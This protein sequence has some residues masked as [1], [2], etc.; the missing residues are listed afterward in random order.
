MF[1]VVRPQLQRHFLIVFASY[2][3]SPSDTNNMSIQSA[4]LFFHQSNG[5]LKLREGVVARLW[6]HWAQKTEK[7]LLEFGL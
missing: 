4:R 7:P 3:P 1:L 5:L 2:S 6:P